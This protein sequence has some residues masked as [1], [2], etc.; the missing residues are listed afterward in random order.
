MGDPF[1]I[2]GLPPRFDLTPAEIQRAFLARSATLHPDRST[3]DEA[4]AAELNHARQ[5]LADPEAR[6]RALL[7]R[8]G[9]TEDTD[10]SLPDGFLL[11]MMDARE[12]LEAAQ[13]EGDAAAVRAWLAW[14]E[15]Q[16]GRHVGRVGGL[17]SEEPVPAGAVRRELNAWRYIERMIE[18]I[19]AGPSGS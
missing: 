8:A 1:K 5:T 2:L 10:R 12:R 11:T 7:A 13:V 6:A 3:G 14:A 15:E 16:R 17:L 4:L 9:G 18:Q 19:E